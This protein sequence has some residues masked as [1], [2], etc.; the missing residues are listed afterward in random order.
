MNRHLEAFK[1]LMIILAFL[2]VILI[3]D[4]LILKYYGFTGLFIFL[5]VSMVYALYSLCL[6]AVDN[7]KVAK[8]ETP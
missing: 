8:K 7:S 6:A 3:A 1:T 2:C 4:W 5:G